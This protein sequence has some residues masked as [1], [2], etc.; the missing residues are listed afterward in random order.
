MAGRLGLQVLIG[1]ALAALAAGCGEP[2]VPL[3]TSFLTLEAQGAGQVDTID[4]D[5]PVRIGVRVLDAKGRPA[6]G[7]RV[8]LTA[9]RSSGHEFGGDP[10][11]LV[12]NVSQPGGF[13]TDVL[14]L[15][16]PLGLAVVEARFARIVGEAVLEARVLD[17]NAVD[18]LRFTVLPGNPV[19]IEGFPQDTTVTLNVPFTF[20]PVARDRLRNDAGVPVT[21]GSGDPSAVAVSPRS[22]TGLR[23]GEAHMFFHVG[24]VS[25]IARVHV[26]PDATLLVSVQSGANVE[27]ATMKLHGSARTT[28]RQW[29][30][31]TTPRW[32]PSPVWSPDATQ[33]AYVSLDTLVVSDLQGARS[34]VTVALSYGRPISWT[35]DGQWIYFSRGGVWRIAPDASARQL[36]VPEDRARVSPDGRYLAL[37]SLNGSLAVRDLTSGVQ[38]PLPSTDPSE[39]LPVWAP[40]SSEL[41]YNDRGVLRFCHPD[42]TLIETVGIGSSAAAPLTWSPDGH[43]IVLAYRESWLLLER[44]SGAFFP[45]L[46]EIFATGLHL[47]EPDWRP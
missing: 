28:L 15:T 42:G 37:R 7:L 11:L 44:S 40:D 12:R 18:T 25:E 38:V 41:V 24:Q 3:D 13:A 33:V 34:N 9:M 45:I 4:A 47:A 17:Y 21:A 8:T 20:S 43:W 35:R 6:E 19:R 39:W 2:T 5:L 46:R 36:L 10:V 30:Q 27:M 14:R 26:V 16:N 22:A 1:G 23:I 29:V 31:P 32:L